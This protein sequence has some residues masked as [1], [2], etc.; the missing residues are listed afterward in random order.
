M[1]KDNF[2]CYFFLL[3][4]DSD[5]SYNGKNARNVFFKQLTKNSHARDFISLN[6]FYNG[7][8]Q[9]ASVDVPISVSSIKDIML[10]H[11]RDIGFESFD[12]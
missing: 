2:N 1:L 5:F 12:Y 9:T 10:K 6:F 7:R 4:R 11:S 3:S 8:F